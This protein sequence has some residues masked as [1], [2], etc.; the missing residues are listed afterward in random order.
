MN[1]F[2][3][4]IYWLTIAAIGYGIFAAIVTIRALKRQSSAEPEQRLDEEA[5]KPDV[6]HANE[7]EVVRGPNVFV[8]HSSDDT[9][10]IPEL[11]RLLE[12]TQSTTYRMQAGSMVT[13]L[14]KI[15]ASRVTNVTS[16]QDYLAGRGQIGR[17]K[18]NAIKEA[19]TQNDFAGSG[20]KQNAAIGR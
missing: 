4:I 12:N 20:G 1:I 15:E 2:F 11:R 17:D 5:I 6:A 13:D 8:S 7:H 18:A 19:P 3:N 16:M 10:F 14:M 9:E